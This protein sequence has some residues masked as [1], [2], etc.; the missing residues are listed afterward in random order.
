MRVHLSNIS[1]RWMKELRAE[2]QVVMT[3]VIRMTKTKTMKPRRFTEFQIAYDSRHLRLLNQFV[4]GRSKREELKA[5][6]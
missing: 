2:R 4:T 1:S 5:S 3:M 6:I